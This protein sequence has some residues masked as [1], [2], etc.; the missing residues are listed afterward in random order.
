MTSLFDER[1]DQHQSID[2]TNGHR[3]VRTPFYSTGPPY[4]GIANIILQLTPPSTS[5]V[6]APSRPIRSARG[7]R[8][9]FPSVV[10]GDP[11]KPRVPD[12]AHAVTACFACHT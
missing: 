5:C 10:G 9:G 11:S 1:V 2:W 4:H 8:M 6:I 3:A 12:A 7:W